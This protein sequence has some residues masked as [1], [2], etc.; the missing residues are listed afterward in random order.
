MITTELLREISKL[1][2][3]QLFVTEAVLDERG[4]ALVARGRARMITRIIS[5]EDLD[6]GGYDLVKGQVAA[7]IGSL[8]RVQPS[9]PVEATCG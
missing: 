4:L 9:D 5:Y 6:V 8:E 1:C 2:G 7:L 3:C